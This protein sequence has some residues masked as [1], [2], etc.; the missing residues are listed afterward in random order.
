MDKIIIDSTSGNTGIAYA[1]IGASKG[2]KV[3]LVMPQNVSEE[4]KRIV[5]LWGE[6]CIY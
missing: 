6:D 4:R 2:Y 1:L 3:T 5:R